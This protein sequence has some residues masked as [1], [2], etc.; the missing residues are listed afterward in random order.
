MKILQ[1]AVDNINWKQKQTF[2]SISLDRFQRESANSSI[3]VSIRPFS[4][5]YWLWGIRS[6]MVLLQKSRS[7]NYSSGK[8]NGPPRCSILTNNSHSKRPKLQAG[9][10]TEMK[11]V[12]WGALLMHKKQ[13]DLWLLY[14]DLNEEVLLTILRLPFSWPNK[15]PSP[16]TPQN[17]LQNERRVHSFWEGQK[18]V[19]KVLCKTAY[20]LTQEKKKQWKLSYH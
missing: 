20:T 3:R 5:K 6:R 2:P 14:S 8:P 19:L 15:Q 9:T 7:F 10:D 11:L 18:S 13:S 17:D 4:T 1:Y 16:P 12:L